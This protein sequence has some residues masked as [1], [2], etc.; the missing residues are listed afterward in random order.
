MWIV[1]AALSFALG[2]LYLFRCLERLDGF[3]DTRQPGEERI[4]LSVALSDP[5]TEAGMVGLLEG[6]CA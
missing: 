3:L 4:V 6:F 2:Q 5:D 1:L